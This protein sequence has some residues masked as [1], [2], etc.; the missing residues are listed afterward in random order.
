MKTNSNKRQ[1]KCRQ[2]FKALHGVSKW[3]K[4]HIQTSATANK[5]REPW[6][7]KDD[8]YIIMSNDPV[9]KKA[10]KLGRTKYAVEHRVKY[11][12]QFKTS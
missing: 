12:N 3:H 7:F 4:T 6:S 1:V 8:M 9:V 11:L 2:K 5:A 10:V